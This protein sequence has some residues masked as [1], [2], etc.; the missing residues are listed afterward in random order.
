[1][2]TTSPA[3]AS[4]STSTSS[5]APQRARRRTV[6]RRVVLGLAL[7]ALLA[8][9]SV[10]PEPRTTRDPLAP[11][12][13]SADGSRALAQILGRQGVTIHHTTSLPEAV[14]LARAG[15]TLFVTSHD[16]LWT[17]HVDELAATRA[18]LVL[19]DPH[20]LVDG[21]AATLE[22]TSTWNGA[23]DTY[24]AGCTDP[25]AQVAGELTWG[26]SGF[27]SDDPDVTLCFGDEDGAGMAVTVADGR[28]VTAIATGAPFTNE[29]LDEGGNAALA[30]RL[31]GKNPVL[32][33]YNPTTAD[34]RGV[35]SEPAPG[36][37]DLLPPWFGF[38]AIQLGVLVV[39]L[40]LWQ[41]R[42]L[43]PLVTEPLPVVVQA[44]EATRGRG[45]LYRR[46]RSHGH[47]GAALRAATASRCAQ[48]LGLPR[49]AGAEAVIDAI[50]YASGRSPAEVSHL[51]YGPP[52]TSDTGL[53]HLARE[54]DRLE[55]EVHRP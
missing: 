9:V 5:D 26:G 10:L 44:A 40:A 46:A 27:A 1:M 15:T 20:W 17:E 38:V 51:L 34:L 25:D 53:T 24:P 55:S 14:E 16:V 32:V 42:R 13:T 18:D 23:L 19:V 37:G 21:Y 12:S 30:L 2:T 49:S 29:V 31:L 36:L 22:H 11:D 3:P 4:T 43:G 54:L 48:R 52:P 35:T 39:F 45:R 33:W 28:R 7:L 8:L 47:A 6:T 41:G 50:S